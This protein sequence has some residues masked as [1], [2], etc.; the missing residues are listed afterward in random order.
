MKFHLS[1]VL[2]IA[3][4]A[5]ASESAAEPRPMTIREAESIVRAA[6]DQN[7][8][9][10]RKPPGYEIDEHYTTKYAPNFVIFSVIWMGA[11]QG[12]AMVDTVE[13]NMRNGDIFSGLICKEY[14]GPMIAR[15]QAKVRRAIGLDA[16][17][18][19]KYRTGGE[20]C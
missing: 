17:S 7:D 6:I 2:F 12:G 5:M 16:K 3:A 13:V 19:Q 8:R 11:P 15:A 10:A 20:Y 1:V 4:A 14:K 18:Y 9:P